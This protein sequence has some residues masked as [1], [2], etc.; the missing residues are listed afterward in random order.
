MR[1]IDYRKRRGLTQAELAGI[2]GLSQA[3]VARYE[4]GTRFP[5]RDELD[6]IYRATDGD[7]TAN[8]FVGHEPAPGAA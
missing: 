1:L 7:V 4:N 6:A 8:D 5:Q 3:A 2:L